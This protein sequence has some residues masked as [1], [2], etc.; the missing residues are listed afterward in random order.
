MG[1]G[2]LISMVFISAV[3]LIQIRQQNRLLL[4]EWQTLQ[5]QH[6][7]LEEQQRRLQLEKSTWGQLH[8]IE[9]VAKN[10]LN[11]KVPSLAEIVVITQP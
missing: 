2:L 9:T 6:T 8:R 3:Q 1:F 11:M 10:Q 7:L 5:Q 4:A